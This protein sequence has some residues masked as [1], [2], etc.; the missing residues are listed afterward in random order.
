MKQLDAY[1]KSLESVYN[2]FGFEEDWAVFPIDDRR[3]YYWKINAH[4]VN[5]YDSVK[6]YEEQDGNHSYTD[7]LLY[8]SHYPKAIYDGKDYTAIL[9]NTHVD[10]N[11]FLAI[12]DN[13]KQVGKG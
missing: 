9:V 3:K 2:Y 8:H 5:F 7:E 1:K 4:E 13:S 11:K 12:Y 6:A 10:G